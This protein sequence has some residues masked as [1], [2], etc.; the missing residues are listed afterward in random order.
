MCVLGAVLPLKALVKCVYSVLCS[1]EVCVL[2]AVLPLK[3]LV[4]EW[5]EQERRAREKEQED[6]SLYFSR[7]KQHGSHLTED[8]QEEREF[9]RA[10]PAFQ[11]VPYHTLSSFLHSQNTYF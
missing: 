4:N 9:R 8:E 6:A 1:G 10:F 5:D 7:S 11:K 3:A 2:S